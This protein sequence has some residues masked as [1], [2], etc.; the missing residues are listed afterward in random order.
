MATRTGTGDETL[1]LPVSPAREVEHEIS[2]IDPKSNKYLKLVILLVAGCWLLVKWLILVGSAHPTTACPPRL[3]EA[4]AGR[5]TRY[6]L[7]F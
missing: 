3:S 7:T 6:C 5:V 4:M 1:L 2:S